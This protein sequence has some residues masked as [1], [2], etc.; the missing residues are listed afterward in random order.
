MA[1]QDR[2]RT[3][4]WQ[5]TVV[6]VAL[7]TAGI[8]VVIPVFVLFTTD[9]E[10]SPAPGLSATL[11]EQSLEE[12]RDRLDP[13]QVDVDAMSARL[14]AIED[15]S[16]AAVS[17]QR[18]SSVEA[19]VGALETGL[20]GIQSSLRLDGMD[21]LEVARLRDDVNNLADDLIRVEANVQRDVSEVS[22]TTENSLLLVNGR[23]SSL[24]DRLVTLFVT[25]ITVI[26][27]IATLV[28][29][30]LLYLLANRNTT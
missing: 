12:L 22:G 19:T 14:D 26:G 4:F 16:P 28:M 9:E 11:V 25:L 20:A 21:I 18:L 10:P 23:V 7:V 15:A 6:L 13:I 1:I 8:A 3:L 30:V 27:I 2:S 29:G 5:V 17:A 24:D